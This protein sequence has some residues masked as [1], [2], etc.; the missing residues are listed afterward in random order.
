MREKLLI[1]DDEEAIVGGMWEYLSLCGF[2]VDCARRKDEA[3]AL[4]GRK[5]YAA[6]IA[7]LC[8]TGGQST[9]GLEVLIAV[10]ERWP[11]TRTILLTAYGSPEIE[12]DARTR[13]VAAVVHKPL[14]LPE[15]AR[16]LLDLVAPR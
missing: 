2:D 8:L 1:V 6:V 4:I 3:L 9:E 16:I 12:A 5:R 7:D 11:S 10:R 15:V 13:G 14:P